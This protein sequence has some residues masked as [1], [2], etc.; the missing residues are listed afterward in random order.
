MQLKIV[1]GI[2]RIGEQS[3]LRL[4]TNIGK[5]RIINALNRLNQ[6]YLCQE[7]NQPIPSEVKKRVKSTPA[8]EIFQEGKTAYFEAKCFKEAPRWGAMT[9]GEEDMN[10]LFLKYQ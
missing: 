5:N 3:F 7:V 1:F 10:L 2:Y 4:L 8:Y 9:V 6:N